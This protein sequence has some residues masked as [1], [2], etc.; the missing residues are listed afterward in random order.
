[1]Y[2]KN[3]VGNIDGVRA[4]IGWVSFSK[5]GRTVYYRGRSLTRIKGGGIRG[6]F[7]DSESGEE[8]WLSGVKGEGSNTH[9]AETTPVHI[10][11]DTEEEYARLKRSGQA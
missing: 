10:D 1:M 3:K 8:Y 4:R 9:W 5:S 6:N 11:Q 2:I 7:L